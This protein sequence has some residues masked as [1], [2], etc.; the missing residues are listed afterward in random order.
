MSSF[1]S[2]EPVIHDFNEDGEEE[3]AKSILPGTYPAVGV[4]STE[5]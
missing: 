1:W 3:V 5:T 4:P 2:K